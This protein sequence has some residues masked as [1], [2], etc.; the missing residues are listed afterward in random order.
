M[1]VYLNLIVNLY[2]LQSIHPTGKLGIQQQSSK[3]VNKIGFM[4]FHD[5]HAGQVVVKQYSHCCFCIVIVAASI[6]QP[7]LDIMGS[8]PPRLVL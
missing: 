2:P 5:M 8:Q 6:Q 1:A 3:I 7:L 4:H